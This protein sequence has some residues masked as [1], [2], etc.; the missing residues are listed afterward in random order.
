M[1]NAIT[2]HMTETLE[3]IKN[4]LV[5]KKNFGHGAWR[6]TGPA[7][8][9]TVGKLIASGYAHWVKTED[10]YTAALTQSGIWV[11]E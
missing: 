9:S 3:A 11:I 1:N 5:Y 4:K 10:Y 6:I 8:P 7:N 2:P